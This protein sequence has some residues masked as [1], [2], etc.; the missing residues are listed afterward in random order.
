MIVV[1]IDP[2]QS[3]AVAVLRSEG[4]P[5]AHVEQVVTQMVD[6]KKVELDALWL[7]EAIPR[8]ADLVVIEKVGTQPTWAASHSFK[9]GESYGQ[10]L[11]VIRLRGAPSLRVT[12][13]GWKAAVLTGTDHSKE[14]AVVHVQ[15]LF[16]TLNLTPR[17]GRGGPSHDMAEAMC[18][19]LYGMQYLKEK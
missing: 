8:D 9:F 17:S 3:G 12:P 2:G 10:A 15:R 4:S 7:L 13:Q 18:L 6:G 1:G 11:A 16:P 14:A 19:A 5:R